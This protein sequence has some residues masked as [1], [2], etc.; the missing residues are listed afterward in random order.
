MLQVIRQKTGNRPEKNTQD[1]G[2]K[3]EVWNAKDEQGILVY[4]IFQYDNY[5]TL[6][7]MS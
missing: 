5:A 1:K 4:S 2:P 7:I 6:H 3:K